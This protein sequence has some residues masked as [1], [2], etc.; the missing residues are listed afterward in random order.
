MK[1][2]TLLV[3]YINNVT[4]VN[5]CFNTCQVLTLGMHPMVATATLHH[6]AVVVI[7]IIALI[8]Q[9]AEVS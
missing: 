9:W 2:S 3:K 6:L 7:V 5:L 8:T 1:F 4:N